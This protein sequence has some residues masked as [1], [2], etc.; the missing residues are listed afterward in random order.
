MGSWSQ[1]PQRLLVARLCSVQEALDK[2][3]HALGIFLYLSKA[4][5][6]I[7][8]KRLLDKLDSYGI[9]VSVNNCFKSYLT[10][11]TQFVEIS[12][13]DRNK[14]TQHR[15]QSSSRATS[16]GIPQGSIVVPLL[17]LI[18]IN[19]LP[20]NIQGAKLILYADDTNVL[21]VDKNEEA[22]Q[23]KLSLVMKQLENSFFLN[24]LFIITTK[25]A[26]MSFHL[27]RSKPPLKPC[28]ILRN[29]EVKFLG[30][31]ITENLSWHAHICSLCHSLS[32][33]FFIIKY[34]K[35]TLSSHVLWNI[36][37]AYFH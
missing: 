25:R 35:S 8:H 1:N 29:T 9:T 11:R 24:D 7:N 23:T 30:M 26:A 6:V 18:F 37:F 13:T 14:Y 2:H 5:D 22:L 28:I 31:R 36:Y 16:Y 27:C 3:L 21:I 20:L 34:V 15:F 4:Y 10:N 32:R 12:Q 33:T 17:F 19:V